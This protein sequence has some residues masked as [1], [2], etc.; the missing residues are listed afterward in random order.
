MAIALLRIVVGL[1]FAKA[2][3]PKL[4]VALVGGFVPLSQVSARWVAAMPHI[5]AKQPSANHTPHCSLI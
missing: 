2:L 3:V 4:T 5:V 1:Y